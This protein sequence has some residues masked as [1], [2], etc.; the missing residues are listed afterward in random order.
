MLRIMHLIPLG[1]C[2]DCRSAT[3]VLARIA[4]KEGLRSL[5]RGLDAA[6][7]LN[8]PLIAIYLPCYDY[9]ESRVGHPHLGFYGPLVAGTIVPFT[10]LQYHH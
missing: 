1:N 6:M 8:L 3:G 10:V 4:Q 2:C 5:W 7:L 9:L